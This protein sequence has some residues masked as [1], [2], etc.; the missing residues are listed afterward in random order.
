MSDVGAFVIGKSLGKHKLCPRIS[1]KKTWEGVG[2][3]FLGAYLGMAGMYSVLNFNLGWL[4]WVLPAFIAVGALWGDLVESALKRE[5]AAKD[6]GQ[7]LPGFGGLL[8]RIDSLILVLPLG[9]FIL[10]LLG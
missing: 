10:T 6:A 7:W 8:D 1:P 3:N 4:T 2:G 5:F 9:F